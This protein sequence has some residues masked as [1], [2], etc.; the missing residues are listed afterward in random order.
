MKGEGGAHALKTE[1]ADWLR[2]HLGYQSSEIDVP[3]S[4]V[5]AKVRVIAGVR[6]ETYAARWK[7]LRYASLAAFGL[8]VVFKNARLED[9]PS[10]LPNLLTVLAACGFTV[11]HLGRART[12]RYLWAECHDIERPA[13]CRDVRRL[14]GATRAVSSDARA[15]WRPAEVALVVGSSGFRTDAAALAASLG[16]HCFRRGS[17]GFERVD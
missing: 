5:S 7:Y 1:F 9:S 12:R 14:H 4:T 17:S 3:A 16:I 11:A 8:A 15:P 6:G 13:S 10:R 2:R